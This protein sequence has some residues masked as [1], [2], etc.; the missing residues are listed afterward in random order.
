MEKKK[1]RFASLRY[2]F[3]TVTVIPLLLIGMIITIAGSSFVARSLNED[4]KEGLIDLSATLLVTF[5]DLYPGPYR[6]VEAGG[7]IYF[8]K[9][10]HQFNGDVSY[11]DNLKQ[12]SGTDITIYYQS[13]V[14]ITTMQDEAGERYIG[15]GESSRVIRD[16][17]ETGTPKFYDNVTAGGVAYFAYYVPLF[18]ADDEVIGMLCV[19]KPAAAVHR[20]VWKAI[21]P[22][23]VIAAAAM[24]LACLFSYRYSTA[25]IFKIRKIQR[26]IRFIANEDFNADLEPDVTSRGDELGEM[27]RNAVKMSG[28]LRKKVEEDLLTGLYNRR[29]ADKH[30]RATYDAYLNKGVRFCLAIGDID[31]FKKVNDTY[32]HEAGDVVLSTVAHILKQFMLGKGYAIRWGGE[33]FLL[34]FEDRGIE[35]TY[36][37]MHDLLDIIRAQVIIHDQDYISITMTFGV[38][39]GTDET[40]AEDDIKELAENADDEITGEERPLSEEEILHGGKPE[41][42]EGQK[43]YDAAVKRRIDRYI[44]AAD[45]KLYFGKENGRNQIVH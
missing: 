31:F 36:K 39:D 37:F 24:I 6:M 11:I 18:D 30:M 28:A 45:K 12:A 20:L 15:Y 38:V 10:E 4:V 16:V 26:Y 7:E 22:I 14:V 40:I 42:P 32:G 23:L 25:I 19:A 8:L 29:S 41:D 2:Q 34:I 35:E 9:G 17:I 33:E 43:R 3:L 5:E 13:F 21:I 1:R 44:S 27:G